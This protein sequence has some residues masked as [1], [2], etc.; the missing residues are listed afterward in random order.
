MRI[1]N[2]LEHTL[3]NYKE[4]EEEAFAL[5]FHPTGFHV[6]VAFRAKIRIM[7]LFEHDIIPFREIP[8]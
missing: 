4:F 1:W 2:Y 3:E 8:A 6:I 7:N 5:A